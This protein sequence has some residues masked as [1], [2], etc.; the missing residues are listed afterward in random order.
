MLLLENKMGKPNYRRTVI[1]ILQRDDGKLLITF[2]KRI[3]SLDKTFV[4][5]NTFK[6]P[7]GG[8]DEGESNQTAVIR[9]LTE[10]LGYTFSNTNIKSQLNDYVSYWFKNSDKPDFEIRLYSFLLDIGDFDE[11]LF[12][13][14]TSEVSEIKWMDAKE[15]EHLDLGIRHDAYLSILRRFNLI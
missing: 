9:E 13:P 11:E 8:I 6:F 15:I 2:N 1:A 3:N 4:D 12:N 5:K 7:Q 10:E 14:D